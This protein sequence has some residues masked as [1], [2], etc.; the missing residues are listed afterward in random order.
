MSAEQTNQAVHINALWC[1]AV[2]RA[3]GKPGLFTPD[4]WINRQTTPPYY[5]N[6]VTL[7][8]DGIAA[9][10]KSIDELTQVGMAEEWAVKDSF[11]TLDLVPL[12]FRILFEAQWIYRPA[13]LPKPDADL[14]GV[15]WAKLAHA[16]DLAAW[17]SAWRGEAAN[18][19]ATS[20]ASI[21][22]P[23]LLADREIAILAAYQGQQIVAGV[24][25]NRTD[26]VVGWSNVFLP[27]ERTEAF[28]AGCV[29]AA[30]DVFPD[31]PLVGYEHGADLAA[32]QTLG[33]NQIG[34]LRIWVKTVG[35]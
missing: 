2:C 11:C 32:A 4:I 1:D 9:Q 8:A 12:G 34:P 30:M 3:H 21:F 18:T 6:A 23:A 31:L 14:T 35:L 19:T 5:P 27:D 25:A 13:G 16:P 26:A 28:R 17:E 20:Q 15:R 22:P 29:A 33:F 24:I 10:L 7:T